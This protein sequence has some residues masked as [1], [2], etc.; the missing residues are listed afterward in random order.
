MSAL[1]VWQSTNATMLALNLTM[2]SSHDCVECPVGTACAVGSSHPRKCSPG[3]FNVRDE[4]SREPF[5][6]HSQP[7]H[8][9]YPNQDR[10]RQIL[11]SQCEAGTYQDNEGSSE[12]K[13]CILGH[14]C[15]KGSSTPIPCSA[16]LYGSR[17]NLKQEDECESSPP[18]SY[19]A[20]GS[21]EPKLCAL[22]T[23]ANRRGSAVCDAC[24]PGTYA[25]LPGTVNCAL[26][27]P[28]H[29]YVAL[30]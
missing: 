9:P 10:P 1:H 23:F 28:G 5:D 20:I 15:P 21:S 12:C 18:G 13:D 17:L 19:S 7:N 16:G 25:S 11:C 26:C 4:C 30:H 22:G 24:H 6:P 2:T 27:E 3:M 14:Y 29:W 8:Y